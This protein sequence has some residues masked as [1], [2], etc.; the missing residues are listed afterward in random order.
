MR[1]ELR[2]QGPWARM[3]TQIQRNTLALI[4]LVVALTSVSY[5]TWRN[6]RTERNRNVRAAT[7]EG[8]R[9]IVWV[10]FGHFLINAR[11]TCTSGSSA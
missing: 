6:E 4:S 11:A 5:N 2:T 3:R 10:T 1:E 8:L 7:F 9:E